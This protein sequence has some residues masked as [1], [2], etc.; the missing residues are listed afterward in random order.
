MALNLR[1]L[2]FPR[3]LLA[4]SRRFSLSPFLISR[5]LVMLILPCAPFLILKSFS[6]GLFRYSTFN[7]SLIIINGS[8]NAAA[9]LIKGI[10]FCILSGI[11]KI[12]SQKKY[13]LETTLNLTFF[14][15]RKN[16][17]TSNLTKPGHL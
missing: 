8:L 16:V 14:E 1:D 9:D 2:L 3:V 5:T 10:I 13:H 15:R 11:R 6:A 12:I 17:L 7:F 4:S